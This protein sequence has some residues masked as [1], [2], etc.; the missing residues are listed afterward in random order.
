MALMALGLAPFIGTSLAAQAG[1]ITG[2]VTN[3]ADGTPIP[4]VSLTAVGAQQYG[5]VSGADGS[6]RFV[7]L[8]EGTYTIRANYIGFKPFSVSNIRAGGTAEIKM[9]KSV[10]ALDVV[11]TTET[12]GG[13][14]EKVLTSPSS[15]SVIDQ[16][17]IQ[18]KVSP[19]IVGNLK[20]SPGVNVAAGG[21]VQSNVVARGFNNAFSGSMLMLQDYRFAGVPSLRV[22]V[23]FLFTGTNEDIERMEVLLGPA[24]ALYGPNSSAGVLHVIT[25]SPFTSAGTTITVD[26]GERDV[27][28]TALRHA[29]KLNDKLAYKISGEY[30]QGNDWKYYDLAERATFPTTTNVPESRRGKPNVRDFAIQRATGEA[31]VDW[32]PTQT[33]DAITTLGYTNIG[34]GMELTGANGTSQIKGWTYTNLQQRFKWNRLFL[35]GFINLSDA[36]N[37]TSSSDKG[38]YLL[39]SGQPIVDQSRVMAFQAQHGFDLFKDTTSGGAT[40]Y[41]QTFTYGFD[42]INTDPRTG[43]TINGSNEEKDKVTEYGAYI[44]SSTKPIDQ[45]ELLLAARAD[46]NNVIEGSM[47]SPRVALLFKPTENQTLRAT[48]NRAFSTPANFSFFLDLIQQPNAGGSGFDVVARGN[49][50]KVGYTFN[51]SCNT[52]SAFGSYCMKSRFTGQGGYVGASAASAFPGLVAGNSAALTAGITPALTG[53]LIQAGIPAAQAAVLGAQLAAGSIN[54]LATSTPTNTDI[55]SR[56]AYLTSPTTNLTAGQL[57]SIAPL[58]ASYN[59]NYEVGYKGIVGKFG[60]DISAWGQ[61]RGDVATTAAVATPNVWFGNPTQLGGYMGTQ[62]G[63]Y[64]VPTLVGAGFSVAQATAFAAA[65]APAIATG[66]TTQL[67]PA[68]LGVVTFDDPTTSPT[69]VY[70]TYQRVNKSVWVTGL[71]LYFDYQASNTITIDAAASVQSKGVWKDIVIG[72]LPFM[73]N[74][75]LS[76][77]SLG[78]KYKHLTNGWSYELRTRYNE[79]Y[80]VNSGV[81]TTNYAYSIAAGNPGA[82]TPP[83]TV[84]AASLGYGKCPAAAGSGA[85]C[86]E[87]VPEAYLFDAQIAKRF[88]LGRSPGNAPGVQNLMWSINATNIFDS[89]VRTFP[90]TPNVGRMV[91]TR[92]QYTF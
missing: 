13:A 25:R 31:R 49:P 26:G 53:A 52:N 66:L 3:A 27:L 41:K 14:T 33:I 5:T 4:N 16:V 83:A 79:S 91:M 37:D 87:D 59:K 8:P 47:F 60:I 61:D 88:R 68:P 86:Y 19:T 89:A 85:F 28:R 77:G 76:R 55:S 44:Q 34:S 71:D 29:G 78:M 1:V 75:P 10:T 22:N 20:S 50:P 36:G 30:M 64:L 65:A 48:Y 39:R 11:Q 67:A 2:K 35:Q 80:P 23:P 38:T 21:L 15:I 17:T 62:I 32:R 69:Q 6:F 81:Y 58:G 54:K 70:A 57:T 74:T 63:A 40:R 73:S 82:L 46:Y 9:T 51:Q 43:G 90:G 42:Y 18:E 24:S 45:F 72:G 7:N 92:I 12:R 56:V 84:P